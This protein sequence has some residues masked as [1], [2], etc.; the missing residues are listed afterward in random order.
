MNNIKISLATGKDKKE[1]TR[2]FK[3]YKV[4]SLIANRV[5]CYISHNFTV[6][7][8]DTEKIIGVLQVYMKE[9]PKSGVAEFEEMHVLEQYRGKGVGSSLVE[10]A[11]DSVKKHFKKIN[12]KPRKI[13]L[14]VAD[15]NLAARRLYEKY[16]FKFVTKVGDLFDDNRTEL[17]FILDLK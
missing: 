17:F 10:F 5:D 2:W 3:H 12:L 8:K 7:A 14:F 4:Y 15:E 13:F 6:L 16:G 11:I 9:D 1:L